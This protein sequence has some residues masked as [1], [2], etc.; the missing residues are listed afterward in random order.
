MRTRKARW[1]RVPPTQSADASP[2]ES[3]LV[4]DVPPDPIE[5]LKFRLEQLGLPLADLARTLGVPG[6]AAGDDSGSVRCA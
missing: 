5:A 1:K 2:Y 3:A 6:V 4:Q